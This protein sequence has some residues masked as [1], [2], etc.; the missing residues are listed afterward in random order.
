M[1]DQSEIISLIL[2]FV[3]V[4]TIL[5]FFLRLIKHILRPPKIFVISD[6]HFNHRGIIRLCHRP[7]PNV[8][9]MNRVMKYRWNRVVGRRDTVYFLGDFVVDSK[10]KRSLR[11]AI[12]YW[13][14]QLNGHKIFI[15]G[16]HD[17]PMPFVSTKHHKKLHYKGFDFYLV[18]DQG[19][20]PRNW[21]GW[22]IYGHI[23]NNYLTNSPFINGNLKRINVSAEIINYT[24]V[25]LDTLISLNLP[26]IE[27]KRTIRDPTQ[28]K[29]KYPI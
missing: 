20:I 7:F 27:H 28:Y 12:K 17:W 29:T 24:P 8:R 23:H 2:I 21:K 5:W 26:T 10:P 9:M 4:L 1:I 15:R 18:H 13:K 14:R 22:T 25:S 19:E 6:T 16:N 11:R 3:L